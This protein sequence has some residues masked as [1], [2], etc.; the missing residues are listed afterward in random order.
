[1]GDD[2]IRMVREPADTKYNQDGK[3][4]V[5]NLKQGGILLSLISY[6]NWQMYE[7]NVTMGL[8]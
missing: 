5:S 8:S 4:H 7:P 1:M 2:E 3:E 6:H